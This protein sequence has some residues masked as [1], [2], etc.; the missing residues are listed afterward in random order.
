MMKGYTMRD[1]YENSAWLKRQIRVDG[2]GIHRWKDSQQVPS[3]EILNRIGLTPEGMNRHA[4]ARD[5]DLDA[6]AAKYVRQ[7]G[8]RTPEEIAE[9]LAEAHAAHGP[10]VELVN[11]FTGE[12][13]RT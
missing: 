6:L 1:R 4:V 9:E 8:L 11:I 12:R 10:G 5:A 7:R 2:H 13:Y 3:R